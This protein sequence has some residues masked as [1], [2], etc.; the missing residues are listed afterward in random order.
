MQQLP[1]RQD[2]SQLCVVCPCLSDQFHH[3]TIWLIWRQIIIPVA[4][5]NGGIKEF[6]ILPGCRPAVERIALAPRMRLTAIGTAKLHVRATGLEHVLAVGTCAVK[7]L[8]GD[9]L[10]ATLTSGGRQL[11]VCWF[12]PAYC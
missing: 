2:L 10:Q 4:H 1:V 3:L 8:F 12:I 5:P 11:G 6:H 7:R 9:Q